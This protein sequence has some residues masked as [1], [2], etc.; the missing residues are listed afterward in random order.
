M[1]WRGK[2]LGSYEIILN[3]IR[4]TVTRM[5]LRVVA[6]V[7]RKIYR[8]GEKISEEEFA[9]IDIEHHSVNPDWNNTLN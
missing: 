2:P 1:N 9:K 4:V 7:D 8:P 6:E 5:G 3:L